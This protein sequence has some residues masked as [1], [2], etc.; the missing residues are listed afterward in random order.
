MKPWGYLTALEWWHT[1]TVGKLTFGLECPYLMGEMWFNNYVDWS[2]DFVD[3]GCVLVECCPIC[4]FTIKL[5][6]VILCLLTYVGVCIYYISIYC[7]C[8]GMSYCYLSPCLIFILYLFAFSWVMGV[9]Q[10]VQNISRHTNKYSDL[11][12][13]AGYRN[14]ST[15]VV[16]FA[17]HQKTTWLL[18]CICLYL[19]WAS[20]FAM[21]L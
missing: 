21:P 13:G 2:A 4:F 8:I 9:G 11:L 3:C 16:F 5:Y 18:Q 7:M 12:G 10:Y 1:L 17:R 20:S 15:K 6:S 19:D 14:M